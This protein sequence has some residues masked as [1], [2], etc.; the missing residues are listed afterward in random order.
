MLGNSI[1]RFNLWDGQ[2][3]GDEKGLGARWLTAKI[4]IT[5][6]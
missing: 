2:T 1:D 3:G 6:L 5:L 4:G